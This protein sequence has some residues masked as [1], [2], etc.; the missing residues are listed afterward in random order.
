MKKITLSMLGLP[1]TTK[2]ILVTEISSRYNNIYLGGR[3]LIEGD[4]VEAKDILLG[5]LT[6]DPVNIE[7][8]FKDLSAGYD[9]TK[10]HID[11]LSGNIVQVVDNL[12]GS[13]I[14]R[15]DLSKLLTNTIHYRYRT[16]GSLSWSAPSSFTLEYEVKV[17]T[18]DLV[19]PKIELRKGNRFIS[20]SAIPYKYFRIKELSHKYLKPS[21]GIGELTRT[22]IPISFEEDSYQMKSFLANNPGA[23]L[24][25]RTRSGLVFRL[26]S[27]SFYLPNYDS[28][29][30]KMIV[31]FSDDGQFIK[32]RAEVRFVNKIENDPG[33]S[34]V[35]EGQRITLSVLDRLGIHS[36]FRI[37]GMKNC[38]ITDSRIEIIGE[39]P[40]FL[41][42][43]KID[44]KW[45]K[46]IEANVEKAKRI[47]IL[48]DR[49]VILSNRV[50]IRI[51]RVKNI[52]IELYE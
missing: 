44:G 43:L 2:K 20:F 33:V 41:Y 25:E 3:K 17:N 40:K 39:E 21:I 6:Y 14:K 7:K 29:E 11:P 36:D 26:E 46:T 32:A 38:S 1:S 37:V 35:T 18:K 5:K 23:E 9:R 52:R 31:E 28:H 22:S 47:G 50:F 27:G 48:E 13:P 34:E 12:S 30:G 16:E 51:P 8:L 42:Q 49:G 24:L 19:I 45:G 15:V 4:L 10:Y